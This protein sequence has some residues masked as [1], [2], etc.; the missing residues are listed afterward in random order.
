MFLEMA[1]QVL[2]RRRLESR[3]QGVGTREG[4]PPCPIAVG[5]VQWAVGRTECWLQAGD[6][7]NCLG[8]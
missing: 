1:C 6:G 2:L 7:L 4:K 8:R 3:G 5:S